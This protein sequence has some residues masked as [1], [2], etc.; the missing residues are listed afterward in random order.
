MYYTFKSN[1]HNQDNTKDHNDEENQPQELLGFLWVHIDPPL[2][3]LIK[4]DTEINP[5]NDYIKIKV[6]RNTMPVLVKISSRTTNARPM[7]ARRHALNKYYMSYTRISHVSILVSIDTLAR[8]L[9]ALVTC[10]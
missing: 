7:R 4:C 10:L 3:N 2:T 1:C 5:E 6:H 9:K 8:T